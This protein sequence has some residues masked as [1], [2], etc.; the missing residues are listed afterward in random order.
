MPLEDPEL[1]YRFDLTA[2]EFALISLGAVL[3]D[4]CVAVDLPFNALLFISAYLAGLTAGSVEA[5]VDDLVSMLIRDAVT[6]RVIE[7][8]EASASG[9]R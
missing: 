1:V 4:E 5:D 6:R 3:R 2:A 7:A 9:D 8:L